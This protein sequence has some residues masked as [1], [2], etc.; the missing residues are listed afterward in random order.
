MSLIINTVYFSLDNLCSILYSIAVQPGLFEQP[1][2][3]EDGT[4]RQRKKVERMEVA[5]TTPSTDKHVV[6]KEGR[7]TKLGDIPFIEAQVNK[8]KAIDLKPVH[9]LLFT[10]LGTVRYYSCLLHLPHCSL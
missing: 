2:V 7:G 6:I 8:M 3:L 1:L 9:K 4:K 10:R 5:A